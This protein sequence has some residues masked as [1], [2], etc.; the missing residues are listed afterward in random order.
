M[1]DTQ[2]IDSIEI[3]GIVKAIISTVPVL[4][5]YLFGSCANGTAKDDSDYDFYVVIPDDGIRAR[6]ATWR[7]QGAIR[8]RTRGID[9][10]V[11]TKSRFDRYKNSVSFLE[12]EVLR[13]GVKLYGVAV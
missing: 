11:N 6:E 9:M 5:I 3:D 4:E 13:T 12:S 7:I 2:E 10:L 8:N 1:S